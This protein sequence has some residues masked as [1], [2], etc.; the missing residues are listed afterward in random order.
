MIFSIEISRTLQQL[1]STLLETENEST[2]NF[3]SF[4]SGPIP[5]KNMTRISQNSYVVGNGQM[6]QL[7]SSECKAVQQVCGVLSQKTAQVYS[8]LYHNNALYHST[9]YI[10]G[11]GKRNSCICSFRDI[12]TNETKYGEIQKFCIMSRNIALVRELKKTSSS[13][14]QRAGNPGRE[15]LREYAVVNITSSFII[16]VETPSTDAI[17]AVPVELLHD[18]CVYVMLPGKNYAYI[19]RQPNNFEQL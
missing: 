15:C 16:E 10:R 11:Q 5:R 2:L 19:V 13:L 7:T 6:A 18:V 8:R 4:F 14:L 9:M 12:D 1:R 17:L 3:L